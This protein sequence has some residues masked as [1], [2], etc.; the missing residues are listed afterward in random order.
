V[1]FRW[2]VAQRARDRR[3]AGRVWNRAD[4]AVEAEAQGSEKAL[5]DW[6]QDLRRGPM[7]AQVTDVHETWGPDA[8]GIEGFEIVG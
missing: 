2:F 7:N 5:L 3:V 8:P 1:G 4:G 6:L